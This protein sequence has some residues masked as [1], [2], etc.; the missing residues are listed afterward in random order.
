[1]LRK[2]KSKHTRELNRGG[3]DIPGSVEEERTENG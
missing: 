2:I 3:R 1:M